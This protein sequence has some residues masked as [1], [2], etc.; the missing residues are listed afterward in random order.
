MKDEIKNGIVLSVTV[1]LILFMVYFLTAFFMTGEIGNG[2]KE[3]ITDN[4]IISNEPLYSNMI[5]AGKTFEQKEL[6]YKV[7]FFSDDKSDDELKQ[8]IKG[9]AGKTPLYIVNTDEPFNKYVN[10]ESDN[11]AAS[12]ANELKISSTTLIEITDK[13]IVSYINNIEQIK[14]NLK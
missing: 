5:I 13:K 1:I 12:N 14:E 4:E 11:P 9:Y 8:M 10:N 7:L 3:E 2:K 6:T